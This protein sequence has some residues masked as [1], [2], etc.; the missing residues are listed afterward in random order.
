MT[1]EHRQL[2][3]VLAQV[4]R[5]GSFCVWPNPPA[6]AAKADQNVVRPLLRG[7]AGEVR[8]AMAQRVEYANPGWLVETWEALKAGPPNEGCQAEAG[9]WCPK[10]WCTGQ[11]DCPWSRRQLARI[12]SQMD[13]ELDSTGRRWYIA[14]CQDCDPVAPQPFLLAAD[15]DRWAGE[16][17]TTGHHVD[18]YEEEG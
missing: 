3:G 18:T 12:R 17:R 1:P 14:Q 4:G 5:L 6:F 8:A 16:H 13:H 15:R 9:Q 10:G 11:G 2:L 7:D